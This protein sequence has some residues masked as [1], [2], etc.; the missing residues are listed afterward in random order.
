M[1]TAF[2]E[3][4]QALS[5]LVVKAFVDHW[6]SGLILGQML[7]SV[8]ELTWVRFNLQQRADFI[9]GRVAIYNRKLDKAKETFLFFQSL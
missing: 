2:T 3:R 8:K 6:L 9:K 4:S 7:G 1:T 5:P